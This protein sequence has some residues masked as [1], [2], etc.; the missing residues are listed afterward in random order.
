M[1][2]PFLYFICWEVNSL[3]RSSAVSNTMKVNNKFSKSI[4]GFF[5]QKEHL[6][7]RQIRIYGKAY[8]IKI[9][10]CKSTISQQNFKKT[11]LAIDL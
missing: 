8:S 7:G 11:V 4:D 9:K 6:Q 2:G 1:I 3:N 10:H 5:G